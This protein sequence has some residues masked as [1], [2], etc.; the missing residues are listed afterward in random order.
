MRSSQKA[1]SIAAELLKALEER[2]HVARMRAV[3]PA[4]GR[5]EAAHVSEPVIAALLQALCNDERHV[6]SMTAEAIVRIGAHASASLAEGVIL[7]LRQANDSVRRG[8]IEHLPAE[9]ASCAPVFQVLVELLQDP[10]PGVRTCAVLQVGNVGARMN[11]TAALD[12][13]ARLLRDTDPG[14]V[15]SAAEAMRRLGSDAAA[16]PQA[17]ESLLDLLEHHPSPYVVRTAAAAVGACEPALAA[18]SGRLEDPDS[19]VRMSAA[20]AICGLG[21]Q[22]ADS[23]GGRLWGL[24]RDPDVRVVFAT[25]DALLRLSPDLGADECIQNA[26]LAGLR[27]F[28]PAVRKFAVGALPLYAG[29]CERVPAALLERLQDSDTEVRKVAVRA[30]DKCSRMQFFLGRG[31]VRRAIVDALR[32]PD[33]GVRRTAVDVLR[34]R[35]IRSKAVL[36]ALMERLQDPDSRVRIHAVVAVQDSGLLPPAVLA[37]FLVPLLDETDSLVLR[38]AATAAG[39]LEPG[40]KADQTLRRGLLRLLEHPDQSVGDSARIALDTINARPRTPRRRAARR[41]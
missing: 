22:A 3:R 7:L 29:H 1:S 9:V 4:I 27:H 30:I 35:R 23:L 8:L 38:L 32:D 17:R 18:L 39:D 10:D 11:S 21:R 37:K 33:A 14:V 2:D 20:R 19:E 41:R 34:Y 24:L 16:R 6:R 31:R 5:L 25:A 28:D 13:I 12:C 15:L 40:S 36:A 26:L